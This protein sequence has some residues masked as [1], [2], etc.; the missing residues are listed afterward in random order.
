MTLGKGASPQ[1]APLVNLPVIG[2]IFSK[3]AVGVVGPAPEVVRCLFSVFTMFG[4]PDEI[5]SDCGSEFMSELT[6]IFCLSV[7]WRRSKNRPTILRATD[8]WN[9][10]TGR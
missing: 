9:G 2:S 1:R 5:L 6:H 8:V 10:S 7:R 4:F 3:I